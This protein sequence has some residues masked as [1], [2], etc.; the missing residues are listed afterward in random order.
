MKQFAGTDTPHKD[1]DNPQS[2]IKLIGNLTEDLHQ[3]KLILDN[4]SD[5]V[6]HPFQIGTRQEAVLIFGRTC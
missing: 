6:F 1:K 2:S 4:C 5:I 3:I